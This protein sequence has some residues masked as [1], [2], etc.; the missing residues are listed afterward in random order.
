[1]KRTKSQEKPGGSKRLVDILPFG[2]AFHDDARQKLARKQNWLLGTSALGDKY[3][4]YENKVW[5]DLRARRRFDLSPDELTKAVPSL[6]DLDKDT[7]RTWSST[8]AIASMNRAPRRWSTRLLC[9]A[10]ISRRR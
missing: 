10:I 4:E 6:A 5:A 2:A 8:N 1:M 3:A 9:S 7:H